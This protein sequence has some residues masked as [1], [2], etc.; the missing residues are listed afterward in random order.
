MDRNLACEHNNSFLSF[1]IVIESPSM[2]YRLSA[3]QV[4]NV[5]ISPSLLVQIDFLIY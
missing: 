3:T 5:M 1:V 2:I 4:E